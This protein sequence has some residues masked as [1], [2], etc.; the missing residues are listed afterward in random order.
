MILY[1]DTS[2][3]VK[4]HIQEMGTSDV[5]SWMRAAQTIGMSVITRAEAAAAFARMVRMSVI[6]KPTAESLLGE[7]RQH[8]PQY[9]RLRVTEITIARADAMAWELGLRGYDAV[10]LASA[11]MWQEALQEPVTMATYDRQLWEA[12]AQIGLRVLPATD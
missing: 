2:A 1:L 5:I 8:W 6:D 9:I 10:H 7:F 4:R 11:V 3:L 12:A